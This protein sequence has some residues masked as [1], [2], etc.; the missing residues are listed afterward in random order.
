MT[1]SQSRSVNSPMPTGEFTDLDCD[2]VIYALGTQANPII[3]QATPDL[4]LNKWGNIVADDD[5]QATNLPGVFAG[6]DIVTGGATVILALGAG[7]RAARA[8]GAW[9]DGGKN[10]WPITAE[11]AEAFQPQQAVN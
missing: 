1:V 6:G 7:R 8:I 3:G 5:T 2:T 9:L 10:K 4:E 11:D